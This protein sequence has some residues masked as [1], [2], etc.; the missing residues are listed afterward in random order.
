MEAAFAAELDLRV[1][2]KDIKGWDRQVKIP[3]DV[4]GRN[5]ANYYC[6]FV[7]HH[8]DGSDEYV[9]IKGFQTEIFRLKRKLFEALYPTHRYT[10]IQ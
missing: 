4:N 5:I 7:L 8:N 3:L 2:A 9:E 10:L 1:K 6:D